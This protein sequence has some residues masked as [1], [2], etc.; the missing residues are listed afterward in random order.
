MMATKTTV[1]IAWRVRRFVLVLVAIVRAEVL[2]RACITA[3]VLML[4]SEA[5]ADLRKLRGAEEILI[6]GTITEGVSK[7]F[8]A[9]SFEMKQKKLTLV[10]SQPPYSVRTSTGPQVRIDSSCAEAHASATACPVLPEPPLSAIGPVIDA[11]CRQ[12]D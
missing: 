7:A 12:R 11:S 6:S 3:F 5:K 10:L 9:L 1:T 8:E 2:F 4:M